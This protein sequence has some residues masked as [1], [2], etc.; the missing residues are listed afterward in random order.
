[1]RNFNDEIEFISVIIPSF[2]RFHYLEELIDS[3]HKHADTPFELI[4]HDDNSNDGTKEKLLLLKDKTSTIIFNNG[5]NLG[6]SESIDRMVNIAGSNYIFMLN[7]DCKIER[8]IFRS[9]INTLKCQF[10][11]LIVPMSALYDVP[12]L[13]LND[14]TYFYLNRGIGMGCISAFRKDLW[15]AVGGWNSHATTSGNS[16]VSFAC[17]I[18]KNGYFI[19]SLTC[20]YGEPLVVNLSMERQAGC[21]S[22][23]GK[24]SVPDCSYPRLFNYENYVQKSHERHVEIDKSMQKNYVTSEGETNIHFWHTFCEQLIDEWYEINWDVAKK[25]GHYRWKDDVERMTRYV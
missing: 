7:S 9:I 4:I 18:L 1:M 16:D 12:R 17:R 11:G 21:D 15:Q 3:I 20:K 10:T 6:L 25:Y 14:S 5:L 22:T 23:I 8:P 13:I 24:N 19:T 2:N